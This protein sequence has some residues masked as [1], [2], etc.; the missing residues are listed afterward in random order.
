MLALPHSNCGVLVYNIP[1]GGEDEDCS[2]HSLCGVK[3]D[4]A[5]M[6]F[7]TVTGLEEAPQY[8]QAIIVIITL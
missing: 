6:H 7:N 8:T 2:Y 4:N 3:W 1:M 5:H